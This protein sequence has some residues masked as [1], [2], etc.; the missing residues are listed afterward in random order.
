MKK[1]SK[2]IS[3]VIDFFRGRK[4][5]DDLL[6][7]IFNDI[8]KYLPGMIGRATGYEVKE[9]IARAIEKVTGKKATK[10]QINKV[11]ELYSPI[12]G[13]IKAFQK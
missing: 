13:A 2:I 9:L 5:F 4:Q 6:P 3:S 8:D 11:V 7:F 10:R 1:I 12:V